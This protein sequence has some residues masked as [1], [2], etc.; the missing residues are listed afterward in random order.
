MTTSRP[1]NSLAQKYFEHICADAKLR[2]PEPSY[3]L[4]CE[5]QKKHIETI[6]H[7]NI[8]GYYNFHTSFDIAHLIKKYTVEHRGGMCFEMNYSFAWLLMQLGFNVELSLAHVHAYDYVKQNNLYP[9]HPVVLVHFGD[10]CVLA[11]VGWSDSYRHPLLL[12]G[13]AYSDHTGKYRVSTLENGDL[14]M[15]KWLKVA[16]DS[17]R[18]DWQNQFTFKKP[19]GPQKTLVFPKGF[20]A[21]NAFTHVGKKYLFTTL[22]H[23]TKVN[24]NGHHS[25]WQDK[26]LLQEGEK[27]SSEVP[28]QSVSELLQQTFNVAPDV[29]KKCSK[30]TRSMSMPNLYKPVSEC[31]NFDTFNE[32]P[33]VKNGII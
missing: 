6:P 27:R 13:S 3:A 28:K 25:F 31:D 15:Q 18:C 32:L 33:L 7:E 2:L 5:L 11:D 12:T 10:Q 24:S 4:L 16:R 22:F 30:P 20:L 19:Q 1:L 29:A 14:M 9:T 21:S 17:E 23:F 8:N 26:L